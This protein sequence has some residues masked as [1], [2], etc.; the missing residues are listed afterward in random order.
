MINAKGETLIICSKCKTKWVGRVQPISEAPTEARYGLRDALAES[1]TLAQLGF[2][3][4][5]LNQVG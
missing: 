4:D 2:D 1:E 3:L 5:Q